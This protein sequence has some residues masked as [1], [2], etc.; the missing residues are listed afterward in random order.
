MCTTRRDHGGNGV[1][2]ARTAALGLE[3]EIEA[4]EAFAYLGIKNVWFLGA[5]DTPSQ[6]VLSSLENWNHGSV[7]GEVVR[8]I[9]LTRP[10]V[11]LTWLPDAVAG[12]NH[13]D[14]QAASVI[15]TEAFDLAGNPAAFSEQIFAPRR[16]L[17]TPAEGLEPWQPQKIYYYT[18]ADDALGYEQDTPPIP[19]PFRKNFLEG[20]GPQYL[21]IDISQ[22]QHKSYAAIAAQELSFYLT[23][24]GRIGKQA[25]ESNN[26]KDFE[27]PVRFI[28]GKSLV[29][30]TVTG[31]VFEGVVPHAI[32]F[33]RVRGTGSPSLETSA[34]ALNGP[35][36][37]YREFWKAHQIENIGNLLPIAE[38]GIRAGSRLQVPLLIRNTTEAT[39]ELK[40]TSV[41]P[42][43][44]WDR[45]RY[46]T[47]EIGPGATYPVE[48]NIRVPPRCVGLV[49]ADLESPTGGQNLGKREASSFGSQEIRRAIESKRALK[50]QFTHLRVENILPGSENR[51]HFV[52]LV[53]TPSPRPVSKT[54]T[55]CTFCYTNQQLTSNNATN[56][57]TRMRRSSSTVVSSNVYAVRC[58]R[59]A[60]VFTAWNGQQP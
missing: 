11:V 8:I 42:K 52:P 32:P 34:L 28:F 17:P 20:V 59:E 33:E 9:R 18:D 19:S 40:L 45:S 35:W 4:R 1:G 3:R 25:V 57:H 60:P 38:L 2:N 50:T 41:L 29:G 30:G 31:D 46:D 15:A 43:G 7:L 58:R 53:S 5:H 10:E 36:M 56:W 22:S 24:D 16:S 26:F 49:R 54:E 27:Y 39:Q 6:D 55:D 37:F 12:E 23:Q 14:H 47:H 44:W 21:P 51:K 13:A 48:A